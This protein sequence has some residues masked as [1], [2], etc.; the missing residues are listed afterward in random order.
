MKFDFIEL[1]SIFDLGFLLHWEKRHGQNTNQAGK[2]FF[3]L[4]F[5]TVIHHWMK[6]GQIFK[7]GRNLESG[8]DAEAMEGC[9]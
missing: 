4:H 5:Y 9:C 3:S 7:Q 2:G 8:A 1:I 6:S